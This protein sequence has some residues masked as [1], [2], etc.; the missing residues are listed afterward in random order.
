MLSKKKPLLVFSLSIV[1]L[2]SFVHVSL[3]QSASNL[4]EENQVQSEFKPNGL[5]IKN[6]VV[7]SECN[8]SNR[9]SSTDTASKDHCCHHTSLF[10]VP[11]AVSSIIFVNGIAYFG[12]ASTIE[13]VPLEKLKRPPK[14]TCSISV[15]LA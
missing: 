1:L 2:I 12:Y 11:T 8:S 15:F 4:T 6:S 9:H 7:K 3:D 13:E 5:N 14:I 10:V